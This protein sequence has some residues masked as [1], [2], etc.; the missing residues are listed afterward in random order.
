MDRLFKEHRVQG[1][2]QNLMLFFLK[3]FI[4]L[5]LPLSKV[6]VRVWIFAMFFVLGRSNELPLTLTEAPSVK[7]N[8]LLYY[9]HLS[10]PSK[11]LPI[12]HLQSYNNLFL[13]K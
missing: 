13:G 3:L 7:Q 6:N 2:V 1:Y 5:F 9:Q 8:F 4:H 11:L 12:E 10:V